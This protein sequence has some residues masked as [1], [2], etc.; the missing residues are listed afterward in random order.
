MGHTS[1]SAASAVLSQEEEVGYS[2]QT[3]APNAINPFDY[4]L[5]DLLPRSHCSLL[6]NVEKKDYFFLFEIF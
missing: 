1:H 4:Q 6:V 5:P 3:Q 2:S